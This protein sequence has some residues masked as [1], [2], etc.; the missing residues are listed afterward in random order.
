MQNDTILNISEDSFS[1]LFEASRSVQLIIDP[2]DGAIL[3]ANHA[4]ELFYGYSKKQLLALEISDINCLEK[5]ELK[6]AMALVESN[7]K[8]HFIFKHRMA[9]GEI[10]NVEVHTCP[11][12][13][14]TRTVLYSIIHNIT[15][16]IQAQQALAQ[17]K[18][19]IESNNRFLQ[20]LIDLAHVGI[21][22]YQQDRILL[23]N[24]YIL[25][26]VGMASMDELKGKDVI[27]FIHPDDRFAAGQR[28]KRVLE[29]G[30][31]FHHVPVRYLDASGNTMDFELSSTPIQYH[32]IA[33]VLS[34]TMEVTARKRAEESLRKLSLAVEHAGESIV[35]TNKHGLIDYINPAFTRITG[36]SKSD[37]VGMYAKDLRSNEQ[38]ASFYPSMRAC[39]LAGDI[40]QGEVLNRK[41]DGNAY[42]AILTVSPIIDASGKT[43]HFVGVEFDMSE[44]KDLEQQFHQAQKMEVI[45]TLVGGIT[46]DFNNILAGIMGNIYLIKEDIDASS[47]ALER[48]NLMEQGS[49]RAADMIAQLLTF[50]RKGIVE[51]QVLTLAPYLKKTCKLLRVSVPENITFE[52]HFCSEP[53]RVKADTTQLHQLLMNLVNNARDAIARIKE[54]YIGVRLEYFQTDAVF[55]K[56]HPYFKA[57]CYAKLSVS[58]N[59]HGISSIQKEHIF[60]PF[61]TT[62]EIGKGTGLGLAMV[63][64]A[65][66]THHGFIEL[67]STPAKGTTFH[68]FLPLLEQANETPELTEIQPQGGDGALVLLVD[69]EQTLCEVNKEVLNALN[70]NV[71]MAN[72]GEQ[73]LALFKAHK[74]EVAIALLD[75]VMPRMGG[76]ELAEQ[77]RA[78]K[79]DLPIIFLTGYS[80][81]SLF[82]DIPQDPHSILLN[83][84]VR[85]A[86]LGQQLHKMLTRS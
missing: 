32:G 29:E 84:P 5:C 63:M 6:A 59:G 24:P 46:H 22:V 19:E 35:I 79:P 41:K 76:I 7:E 16:R 66:K 55:L 17:A 10:R 45:G 68:V 65:V 21:V 75:V 74:E 77:I 33:A 54:P 58:D 34:V 42:P 36:Y 52:Q 73:A 86:K 81:S 18:L 80:T 9:N 47:E 43:T 57:G 67:D 37:V 38:N 82:D 31:E 1:G 23:A 27:Q 2:I 71:L 14:A 8:H 85:I 12:Q 72:N 20:S 30:D 62:K 53:L 78:I 49:Q 26:R 39:I 3:K 48:L 56:A 64:G 44:Q 40:W 13:W 25:N 15:P 50:A 83:K 61:F 70:Y 4:A 11:V 28:I 51:M 60:E 69:D